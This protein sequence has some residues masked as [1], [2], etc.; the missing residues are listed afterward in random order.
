M[1]KNNKTKKDLNSLKKALNSKEK[2]VALLAPSFVADFTYPKIIYQLKALGIDKVTELTFGAKMINREYHKILEDKKNKNK[3][4]IATVC[5]GIVET[6]KNKYPNY[7][8]NLIPVVSPMIAT[9]RICKK[10]YPKHKILFISP[11]EFKKIESNNSKDVDFCIDYN[12]LRILFE[13]NKEKIEK[14]LKT[15]GKIKLCKL[16]FDKF[17]NDYTKIYPLAGGLSQTA[18]LKQVLKPGEEEKIDGIL[19]VEKFLDNPKPCVRFLDVTF[20][21]G[22]CLGGPCILNKDLTKS[23]KNLMKYL[24]EAK[25]EKIP[26]NRKGLI[27]K[28]EGINFYTKY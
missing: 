23:K 10:I 19:D 21:H 11:C 26:E 14:H 18:H 3:L 13:E 27:K 28:A 17:Y 4:I 1:T 16:C 24:N 6:I 7:R 15:I 25:K 9:A 22:G 5:P 2:I 12:E 20:C 8:K